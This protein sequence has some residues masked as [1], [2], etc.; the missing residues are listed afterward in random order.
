M[1]IRRDTNRWVKIGILSGM[2]SQDLNKQQC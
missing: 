2:F 1:F